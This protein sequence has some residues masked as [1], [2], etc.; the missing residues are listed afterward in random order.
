MSKLKQEQQEQEAKEERTNP[1]D[2]ISNSVSKNYVNWQ[3]VDANDW[4]FR[5]EMFRR[6]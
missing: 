1:P 4:P 6:R 2:E 5:F 3:L